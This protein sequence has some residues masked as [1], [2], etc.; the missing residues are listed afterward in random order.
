MSDIEDPS[1]KKPKTQEETVEMSINFLEIL[2]YEVLRLVVKNLDLLDK[3]RLSCVNTSTRSFIK[4]MIVKDFEESYGLP[5]GLPGFPLLPLPHVSHR[6]LHSGE[7]N[8]FKLSFYNRKLFDFRQIQIQRLSRSSVR[9][10]ECH[11]MTT[12]GH[13][14]VLFG[15]F[16][17]DRDIHVIDAREENPKWKRAVTLQGLHPGFIYGHSLTAISD[18]KVVLFGGMNQPGYSGA[19]SRCFL[20]ELIDDTGT[21]TFRWSRIKVNGTAPSPR[22]FHA[23]TYYKNSI[24]VL[25][26]LLHSEPVAPLLYKLDCDSWTW[27]NIETD[28]SA[29]RPRF[30]C[31]LSVVQDHLY[32]IG[33]GD[34]IDILR[35]GE[36]FCDAFVLNLTN[37]SNK[38][39]ASDH[40]GDAL[41]DSTHHSSVDGEISQWHSISTANLRSM[42]V[43]GKCH[44][45]TPVGNKIFCF[46]GSQRASRGLTVLDTQSRTWFRPRVIGEVPSSRLSHAATM[47]HGRVFIFGGY[48]QHHQMLNDCYEVTATFRDFYCN[49]IGSPSFG[50]LEHHEDAQ[51]ETRLDGEADEGIFDAPWAPAFLG[52]TLPMSLLGYLQY[53]Q[54]GEADSDWNLEDEEQDDEE[55]H[56]SDV[57]EDVESDDEENDAYVEDG[58]ADEDGENENSA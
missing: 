10:R 34:G 50:R 14:I 4:E 54:S 33:G 13:Y 46:G 40:D 5:Q 56:E 36:D 38:S 28:T 17:D 29:V 51:N 57:W 32:L 39:I 26:G 21:P 30:G 3:Y 1:C 42:E 15:G 49:R 12:L 31:S 9:A 45:A 18:T 7:Y 20:L 16:C 53:L 47:C 23:A 2:P 41:S 25:G 22:A 11:P 24:Y 48:S 6:F 8:Y 55:Q 58:V 52:T 35:D 27:S 44:T 43:L 19:T 37:I